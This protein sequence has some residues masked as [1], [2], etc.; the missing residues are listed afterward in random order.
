MIWFHKVFLYC[1]YINCCQVCKR[2]N[3][4]LREDFKYSWSRRCFA[5]A[6]TGPHWTFFKE[7]NQLRK[8]AWSTCTTHI[9]SKNRQSWHYWQRSFKS[10]HNQAC[11]TSALVFHQHA[12]STCQGSKVWSI[13]WLRGACHWTWQRVSNAHWSNT[14]LHRYL[15]FHQIT[16]L[17][18]IL[19]AFMAGENLLRLV[20]RPAYGWE[21]QYAC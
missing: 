16:Y 20:T 5:Q 1:L 9:S 17:H 21:V 18:I 19:I 2:G 12:L 8:L 6:C 11:K 4:Y 7:E 10:Y 15:D 14:K 13:E 3:H